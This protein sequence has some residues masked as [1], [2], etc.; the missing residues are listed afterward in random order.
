MSF[1]K[2][3]R[4]DGLARVLL[5]VFGPAIA[6]LIVLAEISVGSGI[7][8]STFV[9]EYKAG[10]EYPFVGLLSDVGILIWTATASISLFSSMVLRKWKRNK[11]AADF[12]LYSA[13][14]TALLMI[15][16]FFLIHESVSIRDRYI[17]L[18]YLV[19]LLFVLIKSREYIAV[20][21]YELLFLS[22]LFFGMSLFVDMFQNR[23]EG[24][25][26]DW[27]ILIEDG[28]KFLGIVG[29]FAYFAKSC[30]ETLES[31]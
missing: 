7:T 3:I 15:D 6:G 8:I 9:R 21:R 24:A 30:F 11:T 2:I 25:I 1:P 12:F 13:V 4:T 5:L 26:G 19:G 17:F 18:G 14:L 20:S 31:H 23:I 29:W 28:F 27:R 16:D 10:A 22:L